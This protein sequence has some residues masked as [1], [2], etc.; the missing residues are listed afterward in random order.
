M[1]PYGRLVAAAGFTMREGAVTIRMV[2]W[3]ANE[4]HWGRPMS[5]AIVRNV[6]LDFIRNDS[7]AVLVL[8]GAWGVGKTHFW[9]SCISENP[10]ASRGSYSY[11]SMFGISTIQQ[12]Q[13]SAFINARDLRTRGEVGR[14][15][16]ATAT[17]KLGVAKKLLGGIPALLPDAWAKRVTFALD[18]V[19]PHMISD[20]L[21]CLDDFERMPR[22]GM[23]IE[24]VLGF[25]TTLKEERNCKVVLIFNDAELG[26]RN[27]IYQRYREKVV[28]V[29][30]VFAPTVAEAA[31]LAIPKGHKFGRIIRE[32]L[33]ILGVNNIRLVRR[34]LA[35]VD[36]ITPLL[37]NVK[38]DIATTVVAM[39]LLL[40][41]VE[42][43]SS[44]NR[45]TL[46]SV[47][48]F[49]SMASLVSRELTKQ[50]T[51]KGQSEQQE[52]ALWEETL[53]RFGF[54]SFDTCDEAIARFVSQ[55]YVEGSGL[56]AEI[57]KLNDA[58]NAVEAEERFVRAW[59][60]YHDRLGDDEA[61]IVRIIDSTF[62]A[63]A[64]RVSP[65]NVDATL[66]LLRDLGRNDLADALIGRYMRIRG[67]EPDLFDPG[68]LRVF[69]SS[70]KDP[71][72]KEASERQFEQVREL[73]TLAEALLEI[74]KGRGWSE[75]Q[76]IVLSKAS[77]EALYEAF[78]AST[79][80]RSTGMAEAC[81]RF[82]QDPDPAR[83][84]IAENTKLALRRI[85]SESRINALRI[86]NKFGIVPD[87]EDAA[88]TSET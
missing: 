75:E 64:P 29:D 45:P 50:G 18:S 28:D 34:M 60:L 46:K 7:P 69:G 63:A 20:L 61:E 47:R 27:E 31:D 44:P 9:K 84:Q 87:I 26:D 40:T 8:R 21:I 19:V 11:V 2:D 24:E 1:W 52:E 73:P 37:T 49:N 4:A 80:G 33:A 65:T 70:I 48:S 54:T 42:L 86:S 35:N 57:T 58:A 10:Q 81:L 51:Q 3:L 56:E 83:K 85:A 38:P 39:T 74:G 72:F 15:T 77:P 17:N 76:M 36:Q 6:I 88:P 32:K 71:K 25:V 78:K 66:A 62:D 43:D 68:N 23:Q 82:A 55:G 79:D 41:W 53:R 59:R 22:D 30:L 16:A 67:N 13:L 14:H 5:T 12:L